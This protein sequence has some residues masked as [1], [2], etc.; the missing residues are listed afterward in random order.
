MR[1][2]DKAPLPSKA[3]AKADRYQPII[4]AVDDWRPQHAPR[5]TD[6]CG[7]RP[8]GKRPQPRS[9]KILRSMNPAGWRADLSRRRAK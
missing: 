5:L 9:G 7:T 1:G 2:R 8:S 4:K 3:E 6:F